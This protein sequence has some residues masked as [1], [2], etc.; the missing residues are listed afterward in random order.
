M[1]FL[2]PRCGAPCLTCCLHAS[3]VADFDGVHLFGFGSPMRPEDAAAF[4]PLRP[5]PRGE[6]QHLASPF[7]FM[8]Q[9]SPLMKMHGIGADITSPG[10]TPLLGR[11]NDGQGNANLLLSVPTLTDGGHYGMVSPSMSPGRQFGLGR[12]TSA[13]KIE[14]QDSDAGMDPLSSRF[15]APPSL[16]P[17]VPSAVGDAMDAHALLTHDGA[18]GF[19]PRLDRGHASLTDAELVGLP[20]GLETPARADMLLRL[21]TDATPGRPAGDALPQ[22]DAMEDV[23]PPASGR[24]SGSAPRRKKPA[25]EAKPKAA[26]KSKAGTAA[27]ASAL[28]DASDEAAAVDASL[29]SPAP[30]PVVRNYTTPTNR[31]QPASEATPAAR[32]FTPCNCKKSK[33][34]KLYVVLALDRPCACVPLPLRVP[35]LCAVCPHP[36]GTA[37]ALHPTGCAAT[38]ATAPA[39]ATRRR[40]T[41]HACPPSKRRWTATPTP[42]CPKYSTPS[43]RCP[44]CARVRR[45]CVVGAD[46]PRCCRRRLWKRTRTP[47]VATARSLAA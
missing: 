41:L 18:A 45:C 42:S 20:F 35:S 8:N 3:R 37:S 30:Q 33:C 31:T 40:M 2:C 16:M 9:L 6:G 24:K 4:S 7:T 38:R 27:A 28:A 15:Q 32:K 29:V 5:G 21:P 47:R 44:G 26:S 13:R 12:L 11:A 19:E 43:K 46:E 14:F 1:T 36:A 23:A 39:A 17:G 34:L 22:L 10:L 25:T